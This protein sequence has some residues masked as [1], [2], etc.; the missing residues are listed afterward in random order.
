MLEIKYKND[1]EAVDYSTSTSDIVDLVIPTGKTAEILVKY[2]D[3]Q[4]SFVSYVK[5]YYYENIQIYPAAKDYTFTLLAKPND[6][7]STYQR[8]HQEVRE[9]A[10]V[11]VYVYKDSGETFNYYKFPTK[12]TLKN[13]SGAELS[14]TAVLSFKIHFVDV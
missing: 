13:D 1:S 8:I 4:Q 11:D 3:T 2:R 10:D 9:A 6:T 14:L 5:Q 12:I 7:I